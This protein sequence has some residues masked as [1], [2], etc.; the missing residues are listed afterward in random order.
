MSW[1]NFGPVPYVVRAQSTKDAMRVIDEHEYR[2]GTCAFARDGQAAPYF[3]DNT[4]IGMVGINAPLPVPAAYHGFGRCK[5]SLLADLA[6]RA[7]ETTQ[8]TLPS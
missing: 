1:G 8:F 7:R 4:N 5:R 2:N 6:A 3:A